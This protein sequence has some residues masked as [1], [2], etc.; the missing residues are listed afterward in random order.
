FDVVTVELVGVG[1]CGGKLETLF[2]FGNF[3]G[4]LDGWISHSKRN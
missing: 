1:T 3:E 2:E 4:G